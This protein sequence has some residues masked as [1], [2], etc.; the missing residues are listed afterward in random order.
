[1]THESIRNKKWQQST[2]SH[3]HKHYTFPLRESL[4]RER[5]RER[6]RPPLTSFSEN[7]QHPPSAHQSSLFR[8]HGDQRKAT[9][10]QVSYLLHP[11]FLSYSCLYNRCCAEFPHNFGLLLSSTSLHSSLSWRCHLLRQDLFTGHRLFQ[12]QSRRGALG[13]CCRTARASGGKFQ[14]GL[15]VAN[16]V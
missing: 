13:L 2:Q 8:Y 1:M 7:Q 16:L 15:V 11:R 12:W 14:V 6:E 3:Q 4:Y 10:L 5:E 9:K